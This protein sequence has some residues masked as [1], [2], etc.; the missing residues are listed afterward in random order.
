M[1]SKHTKGTATVGAEGKAWVAAGKGA[2]KKTYIHIPCR[3]AWSGFCWPAKDNND[4]SEE[5]VFQLGVEG[6]RVLQGRELGER[7]R[8]FQVQGTAQAKIWRLGLTE[9]EEDSR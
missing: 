1:F 7:E 8:A 5:L 2:P 6:G 3:G 4:F 9:G